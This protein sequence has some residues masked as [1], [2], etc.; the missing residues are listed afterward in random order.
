L[1]FFAKFGDFSLGDDGKPT[2]F[3]LKAKF[4]FSVNPLIPEVF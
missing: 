3:H 4:L 2:K 1:A